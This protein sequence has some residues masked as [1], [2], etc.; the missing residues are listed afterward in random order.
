MPH[1]LKLRIVLR[2]IAPK[3]YFSTEKLFRYKTCLAKCQ[4][5]VKNRRGHGSLSSFKFWIVN[6]IQRVIELKGKIH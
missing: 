1:L 3:K 2:N 5:M 4:I 6:I